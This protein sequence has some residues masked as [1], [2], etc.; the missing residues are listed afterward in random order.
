MTAPI[1]TTLDRRC[2]SCGFDPEAQG[3]RSLANDIPTGCTDSGPLGLMLARQRRDEG[4]TRTVD[5]H[6]DD[7]A[8]V[9]RVLARFI[10]SGRPFTANDTRPHLVGV[11]GSVIGSRFNAASRQGR[12]KRTGNRVPSTDPGTHAH[13]IDEWIAA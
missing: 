1:G 11:K 10:S 8:L 4:M 2:K 7:A 13:R 3:H 5:A 6:P 9:D 12:M